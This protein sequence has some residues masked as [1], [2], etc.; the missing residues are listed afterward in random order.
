LDKGRKL[1]GFAYLVGGVG[2]YWEFPTAITEEEEDDLQ[3]RDTF[4]NART[5][6]GLNYELPGG[7][8]LDANLDYRFRNYNNHEIRNDSDWRW[9]GEVSR[10]VG[11][12]NWALG[13]RGRVSYRGNG[14]YRNDYGL[15]GSWS[16]RR[17]DVN[18]F[19]FSAEVRRRAYPRGPLNDR[20]RNIGEG[21]AQWTR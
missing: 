7:Y 9:F 18:Q 14:Q 21:T 2:R 12:N 13:P 1:I 6:F 17:S 4:Y 10:T 5:G 11:D 15:L 19:N 3:R 20:S 8:A 16:Y